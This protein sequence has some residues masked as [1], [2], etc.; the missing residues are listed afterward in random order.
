MQER[1]QSTVLG[2]TL[3]YLVKG[4]VIA[5]EGGEVRC[6]WLALSVLWLAY[7]YQCPIRRSSSLGPAASSKYFY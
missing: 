4:D 1:I 3:F 2:G 6:N 5:K 7:R